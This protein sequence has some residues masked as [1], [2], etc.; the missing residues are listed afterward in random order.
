[1]RTSSIRLYLIILTIFALLPICSHAEELKTPGL[2][3]A[4]T[5]FRQ[6]QQLYKA[7]KYEDCAV[8]FT[9]A[10]SAQKI[11]AF[12]YDAAVCQEQAGNVYGA[13]TNFARYLSLSKSVPQAEQEK[14][15]KRIRRLLG[16]KSSYQDEI[17]NTVV[18][19]EYEKCLWLS[20]DAML[21]D[22][23]HDQTE[24]AFSC[25]TDL[26]SDENFY[27][28]DK[29]QQSYVQSTLTTLS[30][31]LDSG[32]GEET[33][34]PG[35]AE[36][37]PP[38]LPKD[39]NAPDNSDDQYDVQSDDDGEYEP[40]DGD[41]GEEPEEDYEVPQEDDQGQYREPEPDTEPG[42]DQPGDEYDDEGENDWEP[43]GP[44]DDELPEE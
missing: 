24:A 41:T 29:D 30:A 28:L 15:S 2:R 3:V 6:A 5:I 4:K 19:K 26:E 25:L 32:N 1:M 12:L 42:Y 43:Q 27:S 11:P 7:K 8:A 23:P 10:Y 40:D 44:E 39:L 33:A 38:I 22:Y 16:E 34:E 9:A 21:A 18:Q 36:D 20:V 37:E 14:I 13:V 17:E 35:E 31:I